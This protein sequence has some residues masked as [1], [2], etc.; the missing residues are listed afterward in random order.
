MCPIIIDYRPRTFDEI[1]GNKHLVAILRQMAEREQR[2]PGKIS[3]TFLFFGKSGCGKTT[4]AR[5]FAREIGCSECNIIE[6]DVSDNR[7]I[8]AVRTIK[9][10]ARYRPIIGGEKKV[11][12]LDE[13]QGATSEAMAAMLKILEE[14]PSHVFFLLCTTAPEKLLETIR[15]RCKKLKVNSLTDKQMKRLIRK[16]SGLEKIELQNNTIKKIVLTAEGCP[17]Q[18]LD[19]LDTIRGLKRKDIEK[20]ISNFSVSAPLEIINLCR[21]MIKGEK[22]IIVR[23]LLDAI[24]DVDV[25]NVRRQVLGYLTSAIRNSD[26]PSRQM[27]IAADAFRESYFHNGK[28]GLILSCYEAVAL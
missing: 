10:N 24:K 9:Q 8:D 6:V 7:G 5:L 20:T 18:A 2:T 11:Y 28:A 22:W 26:K 15:N 27:I 3:K 25:E 12:I 19:I 23:K 14:P 17:R 16:V 21:A 13:F 1:A 4:L